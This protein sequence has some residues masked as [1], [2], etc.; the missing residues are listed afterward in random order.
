MVELYISTELSYLVLALTVVMNNPSLI[1]WWVNDFRIV[2]PDALRTKKKGRKKSLGLTDNKNNNST[3]FET[4]PVDTG[5]EYVRQLEDEN[6]KLRIE[7]AYLKEMSRLR[8]E[9]EARLREEFI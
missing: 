6:L 1:T 2:G 7:N 8:L 5:T 9:D 3:S 4:A